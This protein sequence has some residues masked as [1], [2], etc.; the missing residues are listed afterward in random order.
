M[1]ARLLP[2]IL[3]TFTAAGAQEQQKPLPI[4]GTDK[5]V[6]ADRCV[7]APK[8][9]STVPPKYSDEAVKAKLEGEV[10]LLATIGSDGQARDIQVVRGLGMGLDEQAIE[11]VKQW[12]FEPATLDGKPVAVRINFDI[13]FRLDS[14]MPPA[15][16]GDYFNPAIGIMV[17]VP[18]G[19]RVVSE[20][21]PTTT[22][23]AQATIVKV[24]AYTSLM[25]SREHVEATRQMY[26]TL[27]LQQLA[28]APDYVELGQEEVQLDGAVGDRI[29][30]KYTQAGTVIR[31]FLDIF[32]NEDEHYRIT[33]LAPADMYDRYA[34]ALKAM[35]QGARFAWRHPDEK[36][37]T[38]LPL[39]STPGGNV[40]GGVMKESASD[41]GQKT[42]RVASGVMAGNLIHKVEPN[43][44]PDAQLARIQGQVILQ[45][46]VSKDGKIKNLH[47]VSG[48]PMLIPAALAAVSQWRYKPYLLN[49]QPV[50]VQTTIA[51]NFLLH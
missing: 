51:V 9:L 18:E 42:I 6:G 11:A 35:E 30:F 44:P 4:C 49:G 38:T 20:T 12:R 31:G 48:H 25:V 40:L 17:H 47:A 26:R 2:L 46:M 37:A 19:W 45:A 14:V 1:F 39:P 7:T 33:G 10:H 22:V 29:L 28:K 41:E 23:G 24:S 32:N 15:P 27:E 5:A 34:P 36:F 43:Y 3:L 13:K 50:E 8:V 16:E 21:R